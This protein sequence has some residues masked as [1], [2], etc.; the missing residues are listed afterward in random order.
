M[1]TSKLCTLVQERLVGEHLANFLLERH[2]EEQL[3]N[4]PGETC[5]RR[6]T[7]HWRDMLERTWPTFW[8]RNLLEKTSLPL[9]R[10]AGEDLTNFLLEKL[11]GKDQ[12]KANLSLQRLPGEG[13]PFDAETSWRRPT[14]C[15]RDFLEKANLSLQRLPRE[16]QPF[17]AETSWRRP[18]FRCRDL[19][20]KINFSLE[21]H[22]GEH[23]P[24]TRETCRRRPD[25]LFACLWDL[26]V[27][28]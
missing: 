6:P 25:Q 12:E 14:F 28:I 24:F 7:F 23:Q 26:L 11:V 13:Q 9:D 20:E 10:Q 17:A 22:A 21:R 5:W 3:A 2:L 8:C 18:T 16:G 4:L 19:L 15:C 27:N 1:V